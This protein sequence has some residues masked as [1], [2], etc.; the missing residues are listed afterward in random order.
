MGVKRRGTLDWHVSISPCKGDELL[1][2][3]GIVGS[4]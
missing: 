3:I 2:L 4:I 1:I